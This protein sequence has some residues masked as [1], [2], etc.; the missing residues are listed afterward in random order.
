MVK[1]LI[2]HV[3]TSQPLLCT[4]ICELV[5]VIPSNVLAGTGFV[6]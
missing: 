4:D 3:H 1:S 6:M 2:R 5:A